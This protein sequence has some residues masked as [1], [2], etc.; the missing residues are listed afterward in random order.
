MLRVK[1]WIYKYMFVI[2]IEDISIENA[3]RFLFQHHQEFRNNHVLR[4]IPIKTQLPASW[5]RI[6]KF[7]MNKNI[8]DGTYSQFFVYWVPGAMFFT[9]HGRPWSN[10]TINTFWSLHNIND[11]SSLV[12]LMAWCCQA[13]SH[14]LNQFDKKLEHIT[15][16][17]WVKS[18][19][20]RVNI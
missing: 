10:P 4:F 14:H 12:E 11:N 5:G 13:I 20:P 7:P 17:Q 6:L 18:S 19:G 15:G 16:L 8:K 3:C 9:R 2:S 1:S